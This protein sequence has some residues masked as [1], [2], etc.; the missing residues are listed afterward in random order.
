MELAGI[1]AIG[2]GWLQSR[3]FGW[4]LRWRLSWIAATVTGVSLGWVILV[5]FNANHPIAAY[6]PYVVTTSLLL[7]GSTIGLIQMAVLACKTARA[8]AWVPACAVAMLVAGSILE[9]LE[10]STFT[11]II[12][13]AL[14]GGAIFGVVTAFP[15]T[16]ILQSRN[17][18]WQLISVHRNP[19]RASGRD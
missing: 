4:S 16:W 19:P 3:V 17:P 6:R 2:P 9:L 13:A 7:C 14:L 15:L 12:G 1:I 18:I 5:S 11:L 8:W 10:P